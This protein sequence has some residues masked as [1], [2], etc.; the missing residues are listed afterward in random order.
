MIGEKLTQHVADDWGTDMRA[1]NTY[2]PAEVTIVSTVRE[3]GNDCLNIK[4]ANV[5][6]PM[7]SVSVFVT[8]NKQIVMKNA[9]GE[10]ALGGPQLSPGYL[11]Q[12]DVTKAKYV[13]SEEAGQILYYTGDLVRMLADGSLEFMNRVDDL[14]KI[15]GIRIE[16]SEISFA[17]GGCHP[18]VENIET[19]YI[20]RPDRPSKVL[21][22][23]L[24]A[25]NATGADA[26]D[27]LLLLNDSALQIALS[28][29]EKAHTALP[30][31]MVPSVYLVMKRIPRTQSAKTD[32]R[33]LQAAYASVD[34]E[35]WE[36]SRRD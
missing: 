11:D 31:Y 10:L 32:R 5:G 26:G 23:F 19:L 2:G 12:E 29:R 34:I 24:S 33:A 15:G 1:Y 25:S 16:L 4:S 35:D 27:D 28:T 9:V 17:L 36:R 22:A 7:E 8:R 3:F 21:V 20:D 14:V 30:A 13:W 18:L 6:W